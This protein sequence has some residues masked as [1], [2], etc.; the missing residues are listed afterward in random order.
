M[1]E[2][3]LPGLANSVSRLLLVL[4]TRTLVTPQQQQSPVVVG[5]VVVRPATE[6]V[7]GRSSRHRPMHLTSCG[8]GMPRLLQYYRGGTKWV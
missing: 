2:Y 1:S 7:G 4:V 5:I 8:Q 3:R 6:D